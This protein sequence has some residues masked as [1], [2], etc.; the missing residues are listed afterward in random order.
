[1]IQSDYR[2]VLSYH[3][4]FHCVLSAHR[5][6]CEKSSAA[7]GYKIGSADG[8]RQP[9][10]AARASHCVRSI[11]LREV[12]LKVGPVLLYRSV[13]RRFLNCMGYLR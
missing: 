3:V 11:E 2:S 4:P 8:V 7:T 9:D 12:D 10:T 1:M 5:L 13:S 6:G